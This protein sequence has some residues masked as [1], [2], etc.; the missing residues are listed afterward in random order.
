MMDSPLNL[1]QKLVLKSKSNRCMREIKF[2][3]YFLIFSVFISFL[4]P[5]HGLG[6]IIENQ[7]KAY[8]V[9]DDKKRKTSSNIVKIQTTIINSSK[10]EFFKYSS[11]SDKFIQIPDNNYSIDATVGGKFLSVNSSM[12]SKILPVVRCEVVNKRDPIIITLTNS[13]LNKKSG[14]VESVKIKISN[15]DRDEEVIKL[16]ESKKDSGIFVGYIPSTTRKKD[17]KKIDGKIYL[18]DN[19][20][21][22]VDVL[23]DK[24]SK[25]R[26]VFRLTKSIRIENSLN[27]LDSNKDEYIWIVNQPNKNIASL[28]EHI[29]YNLTISNSDL[30]A[31]NILF[32]IRFPHG[33]KYISNSI[34]ID[35]QKISPKRVSYREGVLEVL[36]DEVPDRLY[37]SYIAKVS[38][39]SKNR[40]ESIV[41]A[42][43]EKQR[44]SNIAKSSIT[45]QRELDISKSFIVGAF[46]CANKTAIK[47]IKVY[48]EDGTYTL[49]D[50]NGKYHFEGI[51]K[52][53]HVVQ[54]DT[55]SLD[56][57]YKVKT[58]F[59]RFVELDHGGIRGV[60]FELEKKSNKEQNSIKKIDSYSYKMDIKKIEKMPKFSSLDIPKKTDKP[61]ILWPP[62]DYVPSMP[63]LKI[64]ILH[65][66]EDKPK[67]Y[68]NH[69]EVDIL[70]FD[71]MVYSKDKKWAI[72]IYKGVD[73]IGG[74]NLI[75][76]SLSKQSLKRDIWF[77][78]VPINA[79]IIES[80]S[81]LYA[82]GMHSP[83]IAVKF[84]DESE[85]YIR[86]GVQGIYGIEEPYRSISSVEALQKNPLS[87][88]KI[89]DKYVIV[90]EGIAYLKLQPTTISGEL[91]LHFKMQNRDYILKTWIKPKSRDWIMVGFGEGSVGYKIIKDAMKG[92]KRDDKF[93]HE[94]K[95]S[96]FAK[97]EIGQDVL[98]TLSYNSSK[99]K[100]T[101]LFDYVKPL[102][103]Y[104]I[105]QDSS[106]VSHETS[107]RKKLYIKIEKEK[108]Y[109]L[110]GDV[111]SGL[112]V[113]ELSKYR[114]VFNGVKSE[115]MG[116]KYSYNVF[117]KDSKH[118]FKKDEIEANGTSGYYYFSKKNVVEN[119]E[120]I[121]IEVRDRYRDEKVIKRDMLKKDIDY[122]IDYLL[123]RIYFKEPIFTQDYS[124]NPQ[125]I[126]V[127]YEI[128]GDGEGKYS[129][130][131]RVASKFANNKVEVG[132]TYITQNQALREETLYGVDT[133]IK[134][135]KKLTLKA[136]YAKS[137]K[138]IEDT[139]SS[140]D[141]YLFELSHDG[142]LSKSKFYFREQDESFGLDQ[143][144]N[145]LKRSQKLGLDWAM[146]YWRRVGIKLSIYSDK[147]LS[148]S[149]LTKVGQVNVN[150]EKREFLSSIGYRFSHSNLEK[151]SQI[152]TSI[153]K[154]FHQNRL[155]TTLSYD[156]SL[157]H[158]TDAFPTIL[159]AEVGYSLS[160]SID[161]F[162][163]CEDSKGD[164]TDLSQAILGIRDKLWKGAFFDSSISLAKKNGDNRVFN[165][166]GLVQNWQFNKYLRVSASVENRKTI[167]SDVDVK[168]DFIVY[169]SSINYS[170]NGWNYNLKGEYKKTKAKSITNISCGVYR[171]LKEE[172]G[173]L[174]GA[175]YIDKAIDTNLA[176][177]YRPDSL[178]IA[179][180]NIFRFL[181]KDKSDKFINNLL[182]Y[183]R[184]LDDFELSSQF[185]MKYLQ[186][187]I[188]HKKYK[189]ILSFLDTDIL[190]EINSKMDFGING[191]FL[192]D[193]SSKAV[194][195]TLGSHVDYNV[196]KN[197]WLSLG[198]NF[199]GI[200]DLDFS[201]YK[202]QEKGAYLRFK[203]KFDQI[204]LKDLISLF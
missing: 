159:M 150:Y 198:Y 168:E 189:S 170:P 42:Y 121:A 87:S 143:Q 76:A 179:F 141:A 84:Y 60:D 44:I 197:S 117:V 181:H 3:R 69:E 98:L 110:F 62:K 90:S 95:L 163:R 191:G 70:N 64:A 101:P 160:N 91:K 140:A 173:V 49:S 75:E 1:L 68:L 86:N 200:Q 97:G 111:D 113:S 52:G 174:L 6:L 37:M 24:K 122:S 130:G 74:N 55:T 120:K 58:S 16:I 153:S 104:T 139:K 45:I 96:F 56:S 26:S 128:E 73:L 155:K 188:D 93:Y 131:G 146:N 149:L 156:Y 167:T 20:K 169:N 61:K 28:G 138:K 148:T 177:V 43:H 147:D 125:F 183:Y 77:S 119:S 36:L 19:A 39:A 65:E 99:S 129:Y 100:N 41:E 118:L 187:D 81:Y 166:L 22:V 116:E 192:Y 193:Y 178:N 190:Y 112:D 124:G 204:S 162:M 10:L 27:T 165:N 92:I 185:G 50:E 171:Q 157:S 102:D 18:Y 151:N 126:V 184:F 71:T 8:Y 132:A 137:S 136:E 23:S 46:K 57:M 11:S 115:Y 164:K 12:F 158:A 72:S 47:G 80:K 4:S 82:D 172:I 54:V 142:K 194:D 14:C 152:L 105:Y 106:I 17:R 31:K 13:Y 114:R 48:L 202:Y 196:A 25:N 88:S 107:S 135:N 186:E 15:N 51:K 5:V 59:S 34:I 103:Y 176:F 78:T 108:F 199:R 67:L 127:D 7:A 79:E 94:G 182:F 109:L 133:N 33:L 123:G 85:R 9:F 40:L 66:V 201:G 161:I 38:I 32:K 180:L 63:S 30:S 21:I 203:V 145:S 175:K 144:S 2:N 195:F 53:T 29:K 134:F 83:I 154:K 89:K 35:N